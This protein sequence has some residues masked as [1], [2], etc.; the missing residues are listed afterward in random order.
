MQIYLNKRKRLH[1]KRVPTALVCDTNMAAVSSFWDANMA[2]VMSC[3]NTLFHVWIF[4]F[5]DNSFN[6]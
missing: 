4:L 5:M 1:K 2:A 6:A 3:E